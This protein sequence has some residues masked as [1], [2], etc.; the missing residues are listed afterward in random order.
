MR[1]ATAGV[2]SGGPVYGSLGD[3]A[4]A[5]TSAA[6][7]PDETTTR[8]RDQITF[9][10]GD[11][12]SDPSFCGTWHSHVR[13]DSAPSTGDLV[14]AAELLDD[15]ERNRIAL[16]IVSYP[17]GGEAGLYRGRFDIDAWLV[18]RD[19]SGQ[20]TYETLRVVR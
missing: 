16:V 20:A 9:R 4:V 7:W 8:R 2:E 19:Q 3:T 11:E 15:L 1:H 13:R 17:H 12:I 6:A 5:V 14:G 18:Q 10:G